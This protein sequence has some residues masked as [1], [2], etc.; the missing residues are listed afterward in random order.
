MELVV[1]GGTA[2]K[3]A[4]ARKAA[5]WVLANELIIKKDV[6][7]NIRF[8]DTNLDWYGEA[9]HVAPSSYR[10]KSFTAVIAN[11][12]DLATE[13]EL[14]V[15]TIMHE[16]V[17]VWQMATNTTRYSLNSSQTNYKIFWKGEDMTKVAY[18]R[19]PWE[20]QAFRKEKVLTRKFLAENA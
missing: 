2:E 13:K 7:I 18:S 14:L 6:R 11:E 5:R 12:I 15:E 10:S 1:T 4:L 20:R 3:R 19:Q 17:H 16:L 9:Y 8:K